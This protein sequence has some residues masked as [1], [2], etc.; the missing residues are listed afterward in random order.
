M[1]F[2]LESL[3]RNNIRTLVP[4][5]SAR[6]E[7]KGVEA[8]FLDANEN[9]FGQY[10]RYPDPYQIQLKSKL[11]KIKGCQLHQ[12]FVGNGSDEVIDLAL[13]VF[14][15]P[16]VDKALTFSPTYGMYEVSAAI[17]NIELIQ[18]PLD[19][20][21]QIQKDLLKPYWTDKNL[22]LIFIC[23]P[24]N[25]TG[26]HF[27]KEDIEFILQ[28][29]NG[30]VLID[31]AYI[32]F[33]TR[34]TFIKKLNQ[35]P[36]LIV[37]QTLSKAWGLAGIRIGLA[38]MNDA[39]LT[40]YNKVKAPY[41]V[42]WANQELA[43]ESLNHLGQ[44][45]ANLEQILSEKERLY[46]ELLELSF[47]K[48]IF[49][50]DANFYLV[51]VENANVVYDYLVKNKVIIRNRSKIFPNSVRITIGTAEENNKLINLLKNYQND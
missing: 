15:N 34:E 5:A 32:D 51:E 18:L 25:P 39:I 4:Y 36:N 35:F 22:K 45:Q 1:K 17:N 33:S 3:V 14:C 29:F 12:I 38:F 28:N 41:N 42:S 10:N 44:F 40:Y 2:N 31:E 16:G 30:I 11:A 6:E 48:R 20:E 7:F 19:E 37:S 23:S 13:R 21:F 26:N 49:P 24:N 27:R 9:P 47:I 8:T 50:S 46:H 43:I